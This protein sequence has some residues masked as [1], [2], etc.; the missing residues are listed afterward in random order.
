MGKTWPAFIMFGRFRPN[1]A[2][3]HPDVDLACP[4]PSIMRP[5]RPISTEPGPHAANLSLGL[6]GFGRFQPTLARRRTTFAEFLPGNRPISDTGWPNSAN[7]GV[8]PTL[9]RISA[10]SA[11][12][13]PMSANTGRGSA[14]RGRFRRSVA[15]FGQAPENVTEPRR[16]HGRAAPLLPAPR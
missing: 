3:I 16:E 14:K 1:M 12:S 13:G 15:R 2:G 7:L 11:E 6:A 5:G 4:L 10:I 9:F 8:Q